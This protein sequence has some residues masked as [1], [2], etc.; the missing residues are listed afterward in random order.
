[1]E[2][3]RKRKAG[4]MVQRGSTSKA[5]I[6]LSG[7]RK[8]KEMEKESGS[9]GFREC[10][11]QSAKLMDEGKKE[12]ERGKESG[13]DRVQWIQPSRHKNPCKQTTVRKEN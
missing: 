13:A 7:N 11:V 8:V 1:M 2:K 3:K 4:D 10:S 9:K 12:K 5:E 6:N